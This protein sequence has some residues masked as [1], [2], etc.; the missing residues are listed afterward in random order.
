MGVRLPSEWPVDLD[1]AR[2]A[3]SSLCHP[4]SVFTTLLRGHLL[5]ARAPTIRRDFAKKTQ[6]YQ[7]MLAATNFNGKLKRGDLAL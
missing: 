3:P 5:H 1:D 6:T 7:T 2:V 4:L